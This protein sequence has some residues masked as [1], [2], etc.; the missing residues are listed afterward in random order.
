MAADVEVDVEMFD[1]LVSKEISLGIKIGWTQRR[2]PVDTLVDGSL[3][4]V[5][6][7]QS[8]VFVIKYSEMPFAVATQTGFRSTIRTRFSLRG[9]MP[10]DRM[11][12]FILKMSKT[13]F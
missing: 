12:F 2:S 3:N 11:A 9:T 5:A 4:R 8:T 6:P 10:I 1:E 7:K 13:A